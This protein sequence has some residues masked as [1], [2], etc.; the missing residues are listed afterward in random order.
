MIHK[1]DFERREKCMESGNNE[2]VSFIVPLNGE[3]EASKIYEDLLLSLF[4]AH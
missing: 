3:K 2:S 4:Y 1:K